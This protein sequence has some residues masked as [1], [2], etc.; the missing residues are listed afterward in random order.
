MDV[1]ALTF[2]CAHTLVG[3]DGGTTRL[4]MTHALSSCPPVLRKWE[5]ATP[6]AQGRLLKAYKVTTKTFTSQ[7]I[8]F[9]KK[10]GGI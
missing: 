8:H 9:S 10:H 1:G 3:Q 4:E 7:F 5:E 6:S 2:P